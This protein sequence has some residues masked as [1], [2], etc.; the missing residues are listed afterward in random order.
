M[1]NL[2]RAVLRMERL[3][4]QATRIR[5]VIDGSSAEYDVVISMQDG[6]E[7][8]TSLGA[9]YDLAK[10]ITVAGARLRAQVIRQ[11]ARRSSGRHRRV[12]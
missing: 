11:R 5:A 2:E 10:A 12:A 6:A 9:N 7:E 3:T 1:A 8:Y 4:D